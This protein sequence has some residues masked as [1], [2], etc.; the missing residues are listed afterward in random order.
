[1]EVLNNL[2]TSLAH[3][4]AIVSEHTTNNNQFLVINLQDIADTE[5]F[6]EYLLRVELLSQINVANTDTIIWC[7]I[8]ELADIL[9]AN[10]IALSQ[11]AK[12][13]GTSILGNLFHL[14]IE[15]N[16]V[17]SNILLNVVSRDTVA[18]KSYLN[19]TS[20]IRHTWHQVVQIV[21]FQSLDGFGA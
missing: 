18:C 10:H 11:R 1:M 6:F 13:N 19:R 2:L 8:E 16:V 4:Q 17:P 9:A 15:R 3:I 21:L 14:G 12:T 7:C 5:R 20:G